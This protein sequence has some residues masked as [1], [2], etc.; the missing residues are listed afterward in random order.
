MVNKNVGHYTMKGKVRQLSRLARTM[1]IFYLTIPL[2]I[3]GIAI[4]TVPLMW[5][6]K[7]HDEW[8]RSAAPLSVEFDDEE[9]L[10]AA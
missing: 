9:E 3:L 1:T 6:M 4:A 5:A 2:M 10:I 8:E 7:H